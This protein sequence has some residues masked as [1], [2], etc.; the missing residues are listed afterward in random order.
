[1][2]SNA[3][4][5]VWITQRRPHRRARS[6]VRV[7]PGRGAVAQAVPHVHRGAVAI[8]VVPAS[9]RRPDSLPAHASRRGDGQL[10][11]VYRRVLGRRLIIP[12]NM[13]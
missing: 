7:H 13:I 2:R 1:M 10:L 9:P 12:Y 11:L 5:V 3:L 8:H 4:L 6:L